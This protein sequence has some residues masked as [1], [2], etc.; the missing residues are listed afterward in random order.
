MVSFYCFNPKHKTDLPIFQTEV[1]K[2]PPC[3]FKSQLQKNTKLTGNIK[4]SVIPP[5]PPS[6]HKVS[7]HYDIDNFMSIYLL[8]FIN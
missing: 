1:L 2:L 7:N 5:P 3:T 4:V 6:N 8:M